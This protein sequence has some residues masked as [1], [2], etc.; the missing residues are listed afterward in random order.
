MQCEICGKEVPVLKKIRL[1]TALLNVCGRCASLGE[2]VHEVKKEIS[3]RRVVR[4]PP[5]QLFIE[6]L[7]P[8]YPEVIKRAREKRGLSQ[9][10]LA[11]KIKEKVSLIKKIEK[12][13]LT[14]EDKVIKKLEKELEI[15]LTE[16]VEMPII[17]RKEVKESLTLGDVV[18]VR[19]KSK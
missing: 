19:R 18:V 6:E 2:E 14:P 8:N 9:E 16:K 7:I 3:Q 1:G 12:G 15:K 13:D 4:S 11:K 5:Q 17:E 10:D